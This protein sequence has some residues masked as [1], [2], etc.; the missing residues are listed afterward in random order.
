MDSK[1][2]SLMH[3]EYTLERLVYIN[4]A[5]HAYSEILLDSH[6]AMFGGNNAGKTASLAGTKLLL[7][8]EVD[9]QNCP[10]KFRFKGD[11]GF[12]TTEQSYDFYFPDARSFIVL[13]V[14]N[15]EGRF[16]MVLY[17]AANFGY[18]R[19][20]LPV[21][22]EKLRYVFWDKDKNYFSD[23]LSLSTVSKFSKDND[24]LQVSD[25]KEIAHL[26][27]FSRL[28][29]KSKKRFCI[30]PL[31]D[32]KPESISAFCNIYQ[33]AFESGD[34]ATHSLPNAL[35]TL[36][37]M[38]RGRNEERLD[39]NLVRLSEEHGE[40]QRKGSWLQEMENSK[41][42]FQETKQKYETAKEK[43][44][45][46]SRAYC[47][48][49]KALE[50]AK[51]NYVLNYNQLEVPHS[52]KNEELKCINDNLTELVISIASQQG[53]IQ[54]NSEQLDQ[55]KN[56][57]ADAK[58]KRAGYQNINSSSIE[59]LLEDKLAEE[60]QKLNTIKKE[61]GTKTLLSQ[62]LSK[63]KHLNSEIENLDEIIN[64]NEASIFNQIDDENVINILYSINSNFANVNAKLT[65]TNKAVVTSFAQLF[66]SNDSE[67]LT[68]LN[69]PLGDEALKQ[70]K[71]SLENQKRVSLRESKAKE[72]ITI[73]K[74]IRK[75]KQAISHHNIEELINECE[76]N[77]KSIEAE[78]AA[79][80]G[81]PMLSIQADTLK[82]RLE[83][84]QAELTKTK[85]S[86]HELM[87]KQSEIKSQF[88]GLDQKLN[89][90]KKNAQEFE[91]IEERLR[92]SNQQITVK[93]IDIDQIPNQ[94]LT[95]S[96]ANELVSLSKE[97]ASIE[98]AFKRSFD[99][100]ALVMPH[101]DI[102][103]HKERLSVDDFTQE[104]QHY[105]SSYETLEYDRHQYR[106]A[107][108]NHNQLVNNQLNELKEARSLLD[109]F[110]LEINNEI[111]S[112]VVS[113]LSKIELNIK[114]NA[115]FLSLLSTLD[116]HSILDDSLLESQF[117]ETLLQFVTR[118]FSKK[119]HRLKM[120]DIISSVTYSYKLS[121]TGEVV[122]KS[123]SAGTTSAITAFILAVLLKRITPNYVKLNMPIVVDEIGELDTRNTN[124]TIEQ[125]SEHGFSIFCATPNYSAIVSQKVGQWIMIDKS[126]ISKPLVPKCHFNVMPEHVDRFG[127][128]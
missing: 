27:F 99:E 117:Y 123:Q 106:N 11:T 32:D 127:K 84:M 76:K 29:S 10:D 24:G 46:C 93:S 90:L 75:Q 14:S 126:V 49:S 34:F 101:V 87:N 48:L 125:I 8:P 59:K 47:G 31:K 58:Q 41:S 54:E 35:A 36:L 112:N 102:D 115:G 40:L 53:S 65:D 83:N 89:A 37:E 77:I 43:V 19:F 105:A 12:Y 122:T 85:L 95:I 26:M 68:F 100:L 20:F 17:R 6:M 124:S 1:E 51:K 103:R 110:I 30:F 28:E 52:Q 80:S 91:A 7:F 92:N 70:F 71:P 79:I 63:L 111:N 96:K 109:N 44:T 9:F 18:S 25:S 60:K 33:L 121:D 16:C 4:S 13:E 73:N 23:N 69:Q 22:Y 74:E 114:L 94:E 97:A 5:S 66:S 118:Y 72:Q 57:L 104:M 21:E 61:G 3:E 108:R 98:H 64:N 120:K 50:A 38:G 67:H 39:A 62:N 55:T 107:V 45:Q 119:N 15:P 81:I 113:N 42:V 88:N 78:R 86:K 56:D 82:K 2:N 128:A 116:K